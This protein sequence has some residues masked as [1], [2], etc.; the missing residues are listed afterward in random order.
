MMQPKPYY[1]YGK[2]DNLIVWRC[3]AHPKSPI[4]GEKNRHQ[5]V[6]W[7]NWCWPLCVEDNDERLDT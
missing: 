2:W 3:F 6:I 5:P 4:I 1:R 7:P